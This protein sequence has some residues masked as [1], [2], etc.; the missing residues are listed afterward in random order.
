MS[1]PSGPGLL[2]VLAL[3]GAAAAPLW[4]LAYT[5]ADEEVDPAARTE[6][7]TWVTTS[8]NLGSAAGT[9][10]AGV[11]VAGTG[12]AAPLWAA[13]TLTRHE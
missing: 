11:L 7:S 4:V 6:A 5:A 1:T 13:A 8:A 10:L 9:A 3:A 2:P 12:T